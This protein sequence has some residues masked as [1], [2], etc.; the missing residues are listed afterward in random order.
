MMDEEENQPDA[1]VAEPAQV[2][3]PAPE[4]KSAE[5]PAEIETEEST[6]EMTQ[7][8]FD[9]WLDDAT[10]AKVSATVSEPTVIKS[11]TFG[12]IT[13]GYKVCC[14][15]LGSA[16]GVWRRYSDF[17]WLYNVLAL[18]YSGTIIAPMPEKKIS[19]TSK[20]FLE[21]RNRQLGA[22]LMLTLQNPYVKRDA[23]M[24][25][26]LTSTQSDKE[27]DTLKKI[28]TEEAKHP[29]LQ[30]P[31]CKQWRYYL[32]NCLELPDGSGEVLNGLFAS[33][34]TQLTIVQQ[35]LSSLNTMDSKQ[36]TL[37]SAINTTGEKAEAMGF[38]TSPASVINEEKLQSSAGSG[39]RKSSV[40]SESEILAAGDTS[41]VDA[42][43]DVTGVEMESLRTSCNELA[44]TFTA[45]AA[46]LVG[47]Q[48]ASA[49]RSVFWRLCVIGLMQHWKSHLEEVQAVNKKFTAM[50]GG[51]TKAEMAV[52]K[53]LGKL[54]TLKEK[55]GL[56][57]DIVVNCE[58]EL[59]KQENLVASYTAEYACGRKAV[60][61]DEGEKFVQSR[62]RSL[63]RLMAQLCVL[64]SATHSH[65]AKQ[66][67]SVSESAKKSLATFDGKTAESV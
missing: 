5:K 39:E 59:A 34:A 24:H 15:S 43:V 21:K 64:S 45:M 48:S 65:S 33:V 3:P 60:Y 27:W 54:E 51:L 62:T 17:E 47:G 23:T 46:G 42:E 44:R 16:A 36:K 10:K 8:A 56:Q 37:A 55:H 2:D 18:R 13:Y 67:A 11:G 6:G 31:N 52:K 29:W 35:C 28:A 30:R 22:W 25:E 26:F 63:K 12:G 58:N 53:N 1:P 38:A 14:A 20:D 32:T 7:E 41:F 61:H 9:K 19:N 40:G 57:E 66:W 50:V 4:E 49:T